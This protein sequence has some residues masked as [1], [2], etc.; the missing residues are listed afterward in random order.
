MK[1]TPVSGS[2]KGR[3]GRKGGLKDARRSRFASLREYGFLARPIARQLL[4]SNRHVLFCR[5]RAGGH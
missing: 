2:R 1:I 5:S 3:Q 4:S